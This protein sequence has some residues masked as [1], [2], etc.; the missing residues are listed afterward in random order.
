MLSDLYGEPGVF[1]VKSLKVGDL[2]RLGERH[3]KSKDGAFWAVVMKSPTEEAKLHRG[4]VQKDWVGP[5]KI[6]VPS[7]F[8]L[9][10]TLTPV[11]AD[12]P[13]APAPENPAERDLKAVEL[14][15]AGI[16]KEFQDPRMPMERRRFLSQYL[17]IVQQR[18]RTLRKQLG[19]PPDRPAPPPA[20]TAFYLGADGRIH[21]NTTLAANPSQAWGMNV[22][23]GGKKVSLVPPPKTREAADIRNLYLD[24]R[25]AI[26]KAEAAARYHEQFLGSRGI[27]GRVSEARGQALAPQLSVLTGAVERANAGIKMLDAGG[28]DAIPN[29]RRELDVAEAWLTKYA[30]SWSVYL[31]AVQEGG[32]AAAQEIKTGAIIIISLLTAPAGGAGAI[33]AGVATAGIEIADRLSQ[34]KDVKWSELTIDTVVP[35]LISIAMSRFGGNAAE[36]MVENLLKTGLVKNL[37]K[38]ALIRI[39]KNEIIRRI[40]IVFTRIYKG[41]I[42]K[43]SGEKVNLDDVLEQIKKDM[44][45][46]QAA[47][48]SAVVSVASFGPKPTPSQLPSFGIYG[49]NW[50]P[51]LGGVAMRVGVGLTDP[52]PVLEGGY[53]VWG[54]EVPVLIESAGGGQVADPIAPVPAPPPRAPSLAGV[55]GGGSGSRGVPAAPARPSPGPSPFTGNAVGPFSAPDQPAPAQPP[56]APAKPGPTIVRFGQEEVR[57]LIGFWTQKKAQTNDP[58]LRK[59]YDKRINV[60]VKQGRP[61]WEQSQDEIAFLHTM[62]GGKGE[63]A[64]HHGQEVDPL[65]QGSTRPDFV[66]PN[67]LGEVKNWNVVWPS[68]PEAAWA[69]IHSLAKQ[70]KARQEHG[71]ADIKQQTVIMDLRDQ[72]LTEAQLETVGRTIAEE[73]GLPVENIQI[74]V[75]SST[76]TQSNQPAAPAKPGAQAMLS[77]GGSPGPGVSILRPGTPI[78]SSDGKSVVVPMQANPEVLEGARRL[79]EGG[80]LK[81]GTVALVLHGGEKADT[82]ELTGRVPQSMKKEVFAG[83][84]QQGKAILQQRGVT[85]ARTVLV[86]CGGGMARTDVFAANE[87]GLPATG[88]KGYVSIDDD[89]SIVSGGLKKANPPKRVALPVVK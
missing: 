49:K 1:K 44:T 9:T 53:G 16:E 25:Y 50:G 58:V 59:E 87:L 30:H 47:I 84:L 70:I 2:L 38:A 52:A 8:T 19:L 10:L 37:A 51:R 7:P 40:T 39:V 56:Q 31:N 57:L 85:P 64:Y 4:V 48:V 89:G 65:V 17:P 41:A 32:E 3:P 71:P 81:P 83:G 20:P 74:V 42:A 82:M 60:L 69:M 29:A 27:A 24:L 13:A 67:V 66:A 21:A 54:R 6:P 11:P 5:P 18:A 23:L 61:D 22:D 55:S 12:P 14:E 76:E 80:K 79:A 68:S 73:T 45:D 34:G 33:I 63:T 15:L 28:V 35:I 62:Y 36:K 88:F 86:M 43:A 75:W 77:G 26:T 78:V 46:N 72:K